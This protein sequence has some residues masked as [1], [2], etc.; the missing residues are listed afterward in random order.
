[1]LS[2]LATAEWPKRGS[3]RD[4][5]AREAYACSHFILLLHQVRCKGAALLGLLCLKISSAPNL[6]QHLLLMSIHRV[7]CCVNETMQIV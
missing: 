2:V 4:W 5:S 7:C 6:C 3:D 1:M